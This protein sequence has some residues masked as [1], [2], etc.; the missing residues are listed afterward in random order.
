MLVFYS[1]SVG[2]TLFLDGAHQALKFASMFS[3]RDPCGDSS[4]EKMLLHL[5]VLVAV[6]R[7]SDALSVVRKGSDSEHNAELYNCFLD[8]CQQ[9]T[10]LHE[11]SL[12]CIIFE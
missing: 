1:Y 4:Q 8:K 9:G 10:Q 5:D 6:G 7:L 12:E 3:S 2:N 11:I